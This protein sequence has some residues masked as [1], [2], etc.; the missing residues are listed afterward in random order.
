MLPPMLPLFP[1]RGGGTGLVMAFT[2]ACAFN[3]HSHLETFSVL[4]SSTTSG[5]SAPFRVGQRPLSGP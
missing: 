4:S 5:T 2:E 3:V 1:V